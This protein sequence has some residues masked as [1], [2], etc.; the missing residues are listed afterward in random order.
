[1][2][3]LGFFIYGFNMATK[4]SRSRSIAKSST[5]GRRGRSLT[6]KSHKKRRTSGSKLRSASASVF[7]HSRRSS[8]STE[9][10]TDNVNIHGGIA[11]YH[12]KVNFGR[13]GSVFKHMKKKEKFKIRDNGQ[14]KISSTEGFQGVQELVIA[15]VQN[16]MPNGTASNNIDTMAAYGYLATSLFRLN[17]NQLLTGGGYVSNSYV[18]M[19]DHIFLEKVIYK[20]SI[21]NMEN[22]PVDLDIYLLENK[23][24]LSGSSGLPIPTN[25][26]SSA[27]SNWQWLLNNA[28]LGN[29][30]QGTSLANAATPVPAALGYESIAMWGATPTET[31]SFHTL[32]KVKNVK[33][34]SLA[35]GATMG[36][37]YEIGYNKTIDGG[38]MTSIFNLAS[39]PNTSVPGLTGSFLFV[40]KGVAVADTS[41]TSS[42][43][44]A[45]FSATSVAVAF[46]REYV[47]HSLVGSKKVGFQLASQQVP[48]TATLAQQVFTIATDVIGS[49]KDGLQT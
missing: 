42:Y 37:T 20:F 45:S 30:I 5:V 25:F 40:T 1:M 15:P 6:P 38:K 35:A 29:A 27:A 8:T 19:L 48:T 7:R 46:T 22:I 17:P 31:P 13:P 28:G 34:H 43:D 2:V 11:R 12:I 44:R 16:F 23:T 26:T 14:S 49:V 24:T 9:K 47:C 18:P 36:I 41:A 10:N 39:V 4:R 21:T 3:T 32:Y 33:S